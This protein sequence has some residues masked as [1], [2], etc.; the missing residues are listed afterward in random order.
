MKHVPFK[1]AWC[2]PHQVSFQ[3]LLQLCTQCLLGLILED[4]PPPQNIK[5]VLLNVNTNTALCSLKILPLFPLL[6][7]KTNRQ[8]NCLT[9]GLPFKT[10]ILVSVF[11]ALHKHKL[12]LTVHQVF[13]PGSFVYRRHCHDSSC[14]YA[15][16]IL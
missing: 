16:Q 3:V 15:Y 12:C 4:K 6:L 9:S 5:S 11:S 7:L 2:K 13:I 10:E 8:L 1:A 14:M